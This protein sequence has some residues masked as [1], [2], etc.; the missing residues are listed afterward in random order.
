[1]RLGSKD[2]PI[3]ITK[4]QKV[5]NVAVNRAAWF[6]AIGLNRTKEALTSEDLVLESSYLRFQVPTSANLD[7]TKQ[8]FQQWILLNGLREIFQGFERSLDIAYEWLLLLKVD[9]RETTPKEAKAS[10]KSFRRT[11]VSNKLTRLSTEFSIKGA[12][13]SKIQTIS[14]ARNCIT[15]RGAMVGETD[16]E[17]E[18]KQ[19]VL[20][21]D[22]AKLYVLQEDGTEIDF[23]P[24]IQIQGPA[25]VMMNIQEK[26]KTFKVGDRLEIS[27]DDL[28]EM[29]FTIKIEGQNIISS[30]NTIFKNSGINVINPK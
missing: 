24:G 6:T 23:V 1:M 9:K 16:V 7:E 5:F 26:V 2:N 4:L 8:N 28:N 30:I 25:K 11:G 22:Y 29:I 20:K 14:K 13:F 10:L 19:L 15:H 21:W 3:D 27:I 12:S 18:T 17:S